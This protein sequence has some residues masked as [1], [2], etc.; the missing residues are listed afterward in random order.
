[1]GPLGFLVSFALLTFFIVAV[2]FRRP[3][4][5]AGRDRGRRRRSAFYLDLPAVAERAASDR[6][7]SGSDMDIARRPA[8]RIFGR[9]AAGATC[10][11]ASSAASSAPSSA[12]C[13]GSGRPPPSRC[14]LPLTY[15]MD[16]AG[17]IIMLAGIYYGAKYG[18]STTSI[19]LNIPGES[20][21]VVTCI[22]GYQMARKGR[23]GAAL[24]IAAIASFIAGTVGVIALIADRAADRGLRA[25]V[26]LAG[27]FRADVPRPGAGGA[28]VG[29]LAD[30][31][32][33]VDAGRAVAHQHRHRSVHR[34]VAL[35][36]RAERRCSAA[37]T[38]WWSRSACSRS[39][40]C[41]PASR[42]ATRRRC[43]RCRA[44]SATCC[45]AGR[46]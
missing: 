23:A 14:C 37:S 32:A 24:G 21:S 11:G 31:G 17:G 26:Q 33:A 22:D 6:L 16:P 3:L 7:R 43:C 45:R 20:S 35:H 38:S 39:P 12:S 27:I 29:R 1:M 19:L 18:G 42:P 34:A 10:S 9:A 41:W 4:V 44:A 36:L 15:K 40:R 13:R 8:A 2:V 30:Q 46:S 25:V 28:A 5:T